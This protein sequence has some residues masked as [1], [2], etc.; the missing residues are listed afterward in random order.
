MEILTL[1]LTFPESNEFNA[2]LLGKA[3]LFCLPPFDLPR[4]R[5]G[6]FNFPFFLKKT[7]IQRA[8]RRK[9]ELL[10]KYFYRA[11]FYKRN[12]FEDEIERGRAE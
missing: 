1:F 5:R 4:L 8:N 9:A 12:S 6:F 7:E 11:S 2:P 10:I 3:I